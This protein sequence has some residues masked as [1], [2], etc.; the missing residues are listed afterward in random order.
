[1]KKWNLFNSFAILL[2]SSLPT[3]AII[4]KKIIETKIVYE[5]VNTRKIKQSR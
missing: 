5:K 4:D 3:F 2:M 1:M